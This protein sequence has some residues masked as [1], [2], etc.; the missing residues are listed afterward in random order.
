MK[1]F[2]V[3]VFLAVLLL[4]LAAFFAMASGGN[5]APSKTQYGK[6]APTG[7]YLDLFTCT[8]WQTGSCFAY[9]GNPTWYPADTPFHLSGGWQF[10]NG[11]N[12]PKG[13]NLQ[14]VVDGNVTP[15]TFTYLD[16][17]GS[18]RNPP[19]EWW[20][21]NFPSGLSAGVHTLTI[22]YVNCSLSPGPILEGPLSS[23]CTLS[24]QVT[25]Q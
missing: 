2:L 19:G 22:T 5:A 6:N 1:K 8:S 25:F 15:A 24:M 23:G 3:A 11:P 16:K 4:A 12:P 21:L 14:F 9:S 10:A 17:T 20:V 7:P 13:A 18:V